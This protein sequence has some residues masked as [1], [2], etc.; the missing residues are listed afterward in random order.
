MSSGMGS[1]FLAPPLASLN[2]TTIWR[3]LCSL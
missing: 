1:E 2:V 3:M